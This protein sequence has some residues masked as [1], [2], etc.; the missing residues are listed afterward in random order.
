MQAEDVTDPDD[1]PAQPAHPR[2][3]PY[4]SAASLN[5]AAPELQPA[6]NAPRLY[7]QLKL[8]DLPGVKV[9]GRKKKGGHL[10]VPARR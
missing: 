5:S 10:C 9:I 6:S 4:L 1:P 7:C 2:A 3:D 8:R